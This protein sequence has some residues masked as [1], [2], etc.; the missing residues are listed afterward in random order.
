AL[1]RIAIQI[2]EQQQKSWRQSRQIMRGTRKSSLS[3]RQHCATAKRRVGTSRPTM[4]PR[5]G[6]T[7]GKSFLEFFVTSIDF[8]Q[9]IQV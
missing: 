8:F 9:Q 1:R 7:F 2:M 5:S 3:P 4:L 6:F